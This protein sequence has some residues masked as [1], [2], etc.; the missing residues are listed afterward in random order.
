MTATAQPTKLGARSRQSACLAVLAIPVLRRIGARP[1]P[2]MVRSASW[3]ADHGIG[4]R[5]ARLLFQTRGRCAG[6]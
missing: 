6:E 3:A 2:R 1:S 5:E 4:A